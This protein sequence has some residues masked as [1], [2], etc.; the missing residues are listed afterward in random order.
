MS[1]SKTNIDWP[2][3]T[4]TWNPAVG[5]VR[6]CYYCYARDLHTKRHDAFKNGK[7]RKCKQYEQP[8]TTMQF[9]YDRL[10]KS[11]PKN[12]K[13]IF[14][15]SMTDFAF[16]GIENGYT[17]MVFD[18]CG[19]FPEIEFMFLTKNPYA[20]D[21]L[22]IPKNVMCGVTFTCAYTFGY[23]RK[24]FDVIKKISQFNR[25]FISIEPLMGL[26]LPCN[27]L[28]V[29]LVICGP[30]TGKKALPPKDAWIE[31]IINNVPKE[32]LYFKK[33]MRRYL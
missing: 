31:S 5:C 20:Y 19:S 3:L 17:Q 21:N 29:E 6:N 33:A 4:H 15:G 32:K 27:L 9:F 2:G 30:M 7:L 26:F 24:Q 12:A 13:R 1:F 11:P 14:V 23:L 22:N 28:N 16:W 8:F 18:Y 10:K 25:P